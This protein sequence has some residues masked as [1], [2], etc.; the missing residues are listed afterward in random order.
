MK[1]FAFKTIQAKLTFWFVVVAMIPLSIALLVTYEQRINVIENRSLEK[2]SAIRD[3]K[4]GR[5]Q[6]WLSERLHDTAVIAR[7][8]EDARLAYLF[9]KESYNKKDLMEI[10]AIKGQLEHSI[11]GRAAY[12]E[13]FLINPS[14]GEI[15]IS[16]RAKSE[17]TDKLKSPY[18]TGVIQSRDSYITDIHYSE[19]ISKNTIAISKP[20]FG[21]QYEDER[22]IAVLVALIDL[23]N[24]LY[25]ILL[26]KV[27][28]GRTGETLIVNKDVVAL[29]ELRWHDSAPLNFKITSL[30][31]INA[32]QGKTG[33]LI[34]QDYRG[35]EIVAAYTYVPETG[36]GFVT[37]QDV[38]ELNAPIEEM[39]FNFLLLFFI[40]LPLI[41]IAAYFSSK[42]L[43][44]PII[45]INNAAKRIR[46]GDYS[47]R[48]TIDSHDELGSLADS[49][50]EMSDSIESRI[51]IQS[52]INKQLTKQTT[53]L[54]K[55]RLHAEDSSRAKSYFLANM[56]HEI[57][58]PMNTI[59]GFTYLLLRDN[60]TPKQSDRLN[61]IN[62]AA[63]HL[64]KIINDMLDIS[65]VEAGKLT[66]ESA[67]FSLESIFDQ[68]QSMLNVQA[69]EK[70]LI[71]EIDLDAAPIWLRGD[72]M[73]LRQ[74]LLNYV[75]NAV[76][77]SEQGTIFL[78]A[79]KIQEQNNE[80]LVRFEV[81][82]CGIGIAREKLSRLFQVFEQL[83][84]S[85]SRKLGGTGLGLAITRHLAEI[86]GGE[87]GV[88]SELGKGS[89]FWFTARLARGHENKSKID[90]V[91]ESN[92]EIVLRTHYAGS[93][94]L[95]VEDNDINRE[96]A[97]D[98]LCRMNLVVDLAKNGQEAVN[99]ANEFDYDLILMDVQM[100]VM[101][102]LEATHLIRLLEGKAEIP[103]LAMTANIFLEDRESCRKVG[104]NDFIAK[105]INPRKL[106]LALIHWLSK[107]DSLMSEP[108]TESA[109]VSPNAVTEGDTHLRNQLEEIDGVDVTLGLQNLHDDINRYLQLLRQID[110]R[111]GGD[112]VRL[113]TELTE[114]K[115]DKARFIAHTLKGATGTLGLT[116]L[117]ALTK[118]LEEALRRHDDEHCYDEINRFIDVVYMEQ[119]AFHQALSNVA[120]QKQP[121]QEVKPSPAEGRAILNRLNALLNQADT[122]VNNV[123]AQSKAILKVLYGTSA[124]ELGQQIEAFDYQEAQKTIKIMSAIDLDH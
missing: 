89:L 85:T 77:F 1:L 74:A 27:G 87:V 99:K 120:E 108:P 35:K 92:A 21:K 51:A 31:A 19:L 40:S 42:T 18:L 62:A 116:R 66:L 15:L 43:S 58:T 112:M 8:I 20:I 121:V 46:A 14:T 81:Q 63:D 2:L 97:Q 79:K 102:G 30:P 94:I 78:R 22:I 96:V 82:D 32:A 44:A 68:L 124:E 7:T 39:L 45:K 91:A 49:V 122:E 114:G 73:R 75:A 29:S 83:D 60:L 57:R 95:I 16:T 80:I 70:G 55:A 34:T 17:G 9:T 25:K 118:K 88:E 90:S 103:I 38:N 26:D 72:Q 13:I 113:R 123:F 12:S 76:K 3:L 69:K 61:K 105:P 65:K 109:N 48:T 37:K 110:A 50:N 106:Y 23:E 100:P 54:T 104:M 111:H 59:T 71:F 107:R 119:C 33:A 53:E 98:I 6:G 64:L 11:R 24:S 10:A 56:S 67:D 4:V 115:L 5:L 41:I 101:D 52:K 84:A 28:L 117:Q 36:W 47:V 86:M 93:R